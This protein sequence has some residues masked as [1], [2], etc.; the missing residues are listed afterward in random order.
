MHR[1]VCLNK[2]VLH[3]HNGIIGYMLSH[4]RL[5]EILEYDSNTGI[6]T[7]LSPTSYRVKKGGVAGSTTSDGRITIMIQGVNYR[8][9]RLAWFYTYREWPSLQVDHKNENPSD[10]RMSNL[11]LATDA[12]NKQNLSRPR[13]HNTSKL[14]GASLHKASGKWTSQI[15]HNGKKVHLGYFLTPE[16]ASVAYWNAKHELHPFWSEV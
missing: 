9:H 16:E 13:K 1:Y 10:N 7:W 11:R 5:Q 4:A 3:V 15:R 8:A 12:Q 2:V 6:F 14:L